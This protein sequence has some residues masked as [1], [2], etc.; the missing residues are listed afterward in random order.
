MKHKNVRNTSMLELERI[1]G[2]RK[3]Q[4][5]ASQ[6]FFP[7]ITCMQGLAHQL[8]QSALEEALARIEAEVADLASK[9]LPLGATEQ[10]EKLLCDFCV[11]REASN[12]AAENGAMTG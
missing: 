5:R 9:I 11:R 7:V 3:Q 10:V 4:V 12:N 1:D 8:M 2:P 6:L